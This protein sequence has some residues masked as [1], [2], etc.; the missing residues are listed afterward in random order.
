MKATIQ[1]VRECVQ[2]GSLYK[3][4]CLDLV[5]T[6]RFRYSN[7]EYVILIEDETPFLIKIRKLF[8]FIAET[9]E[10]SFNIGE[11][12]TLLIPAELLS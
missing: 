7:G 4:L 6:S 12:I 2:E 1:R 10:V 3:V 8:D 9:E 11:D 5:V